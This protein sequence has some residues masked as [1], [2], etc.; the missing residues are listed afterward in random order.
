MD[1]EKCK[2]WGL[3]SLR[4]LTMVPNHS[5]QVQISPPFLWLGAHHVTS[6]LLLTNNGLLMRKVIQLFLAANNILLMC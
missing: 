1:F 2:N 4:D 5:M 3:F 6:K